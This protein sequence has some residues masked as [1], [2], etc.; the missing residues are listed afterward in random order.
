M[1]FTQDRYIKLLSIVTILFA[2]MLWAGIARADDSPPALPTLPPDEPTTVDTST[3]TS[4]TSGT[5]ATSAATSTSSGPV[6]T[7]VLVLLAI[8]AFY[9]LRKYFQGK[10]YRL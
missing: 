6:E 5:A 1:A 9:S 8:V 7:G 2:V 10:K 4:S 3:T